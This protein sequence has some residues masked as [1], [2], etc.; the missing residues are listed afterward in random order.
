VSGARP[1]LTERTTDTAGA[2]DADFQRIAGT[3]L[4]RQHAG[5][6]GCCRSAQQAAALFVDWQFV[7]CIHSLGLIEPDVFRL[8]G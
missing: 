4:Q 6:C 1:R 8:A 3:R 5:E 2:D 7:H